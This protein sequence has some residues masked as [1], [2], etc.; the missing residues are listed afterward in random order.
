MNALTNEIETNYTLANVTSSISYL[1]IK[2]MSNGDWVAQIPING[3]ALYLAVI[4]GNTSELIQ[5]DITTNL[6]TSSG[7]LDMLVYSDNSIGIFFYRSSS[8]YYKRYSSSLVIINAATELVSTSIDFDVVIYK[9]G[10]LLMNLDPQAFTVSQYTQAGTN[11][12]D[13]IVQPNP[14]VGTVSLPNLVHLQT[15]LLTYYR[16]ANAPSLFVNL[17]VYN[18]SDLTYLANYTYDSSY[19]GT[20]LDIAPLANDLAGT[21]WDFFARSGRSARLTFCIFFKCTTI[22]LVWLK[23]CNSPVD[24]FSK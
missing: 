9:T 7:L 8:L 15:H 2:S 23:S 11:K 22:K 3:S 10:F 19:L 5:Q 18:S 20:V 4:N 13:V 17:V 6:S 21:C 24:R 1:L 14:Q 12:Q 16:V